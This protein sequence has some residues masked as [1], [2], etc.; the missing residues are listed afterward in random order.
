M[1]LKML[2]CAVFSAFTLVACGGG[3]SSSNDSYNGSNNSNGSNNNGSSNNTDQVWHAFY[4]EA[5]GPN[6]DALG[7][8]TDRF[9]INNGKYYA[10]NFNT[11]NNEDLSY[12][13]FTVTADGVYEDGPR[14]SK[15]GVYIGDAKINGDTWTLTPYS[16]IGSKGLIYK[17]Q[18]KTIDISGQKYNETLTPYTDLI[19]KN[20]FPSD[21]YISNGEKR[22]YD[23]NKATVF[24]SGS[25]CL[26]QVQ[27]ET[28]QN[29]IELDIDT[30]NSDSVQKIWTELSNKSAND[31][32]KKLF[33]DTTAYITYQ[34]SEADTYAQY[35]NDLY[36]GNYYPKGVEFNLDDEIRDLKSDANDLTGTRKELL[37]AYANSLATSCTIYNDTAGQFVLKSLQN[38]K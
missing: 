9:T 22:Y 17:V 11:H 18:Y 10:S 5:D 1:K 4:L 24:P 2:S 8:E 21:V 15:L 37:L 35:K 31:I 14:D 12:T 30:K 25:K 16:A 19:I 20:N 3:G 38:F 23:A 13:T 33:K 36:S 26:V 29:Y 6:S 27:S 34:Y 28:N 32:D 7:Y